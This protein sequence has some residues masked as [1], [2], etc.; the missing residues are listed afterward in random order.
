MKNES[1][2]IEAASRTLKSELSVS[3]VILFGSTPKQY[4]KW[5]AVLTISK[6]DRC[7]EKRGFK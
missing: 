4:Q 6:M 2:A 7:F 1:E 3:K 5:I